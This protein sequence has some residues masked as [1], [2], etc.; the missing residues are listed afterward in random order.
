[1]NTLY[2]F[3]DDLRVE[4]NIHFKNAFDSSKKLFC[5]YVIPTNFYV[6]NE[7]G[8]EEWSGHRKKVLIQALSSLIEEL[9]A[10]NLEL[11]LFEDNKKIIDF[12]LLNKID[13]LF[14]SKNPYKFENEILKLIPSQVK[15]K[16]DLN[17]FL[18][19][20]SDSDLSI[21]DL[22]S[23]T[24][25][26][27]IVEGHDW[28]TKNLPLKINEKGK[29]NHFPKDNESKHNIINAKDWVEKYVNKLRNI[30]ISFNL[31]AD[32]NFALNQV[33]DYV[34][35]Q[36]NIKTY[37]E[38]RNGMLNFNDST[39]WSTGLALGTLSPAE[40]FK[41]I[42][43]FENKEVSNS[44]T[45]WL[46]L[47]LLWR[48]YFKYVGLKYGDQMFSLKGIEG[49]HHKEKHKFNDINKTKDINNN[50]DLF[51]KWTLGKTK[52][53]FIN[54][55]MIELK[56]TG[57][58]SNRGRQNVASYLCHELNLPWTWGAKWFESCLI[59]YDPSSNYGNW[60]YISGV[61]GWGSHKFDYDWQ[62]QTYDPDKSYQK[63]WL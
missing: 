61:G 32:R 2:L 48:D 51:Q 17:S 6:I 31:I 11:L 57:F 20:Y 21:R 56:T 10:L 12:T 35:N 62:S 30:E 19:S 59:D 41:E 47:E 3:Q 53:S 23:F 1:M 29:H 50:F 42:V 38:T 63:K 9:K 24:K 13:Y 58:M 33:K 8:F 34:W 15:I 7:L 5:A 26:R 14:K 54:A 55:N 44:S 49:A 40:V 46:K 22:K 45:Y 27:K 60:Q 43:E 25:F 39:K 28:P 18:T 52:N 36:K 16:T 4:N 37:K